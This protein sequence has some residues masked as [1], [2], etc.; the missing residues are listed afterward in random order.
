MELAGED[1]PAAT[2]NDILSPPKRPRSSFSESTL[3]KRKEASAA[4]IG[5]DGALIDSNG[6]SVEQHVPSRRRDT[7]STEGANGA[8]V[9]FSG[10]TG[11]IE[12]K[13]HIYGKEVEN[14]KYRGVKAGCRESKQEKGV[15]KEGRME[16][17][18]NI[19]G[20]GVRGQREG[21]RMSTLFG[22]SSAI[23]I[24]ANY[25]RNREERR[26]GREEG[27]RYKVLGSMELA[28]E[29][30]DKR[31]SSGLKYGI[32]N[33]DG[34]EKGLDGNKGLGSNEEGLREKGLEKAKIDGW[35]V[36]ERWILG[37][38]GEES[39]EKEDVVRRVPGRDE[40]KRII[41]PLL[42][43]ESVFDEQ[44]YVVSG[45]WMKKYCA[46][47]EEC[48][49]Y[50]MKIGPVDQTSLMLE[51]R[52]KDGLLKGKDYEII[53]ST[54]WEY[55]VTWFGVKGEA[56]FQEA[57]EARE[58]Q[59]KTKS[60]PVDSGMGGCV[61]E[62]YVFRLIR[63]KLGSLDGSIGTKGSEGEDDT[64][65]NED[66]IITSKIPSLTTMNPLDESYEHSMMTDA[67][68]EL[69]SDDADEFEWP[70]NQTMMT[71]KTSEMSEEVVPSK[72][73]TSTS[74]SVYLTIDGNATVVALLQSI[75]QTLGLIPTQ[76]VQLWYQGK[77]VMTSWTMLPQETTVKSL[78]LSLNPVLLVETT[79][80][81]V[82]APPTPLST[83]PSSG[84]FSCIFDK[85]QTSSEP[86][87]FPGIQTTSLSKIG[88]VGLQN[89]G[90]SCYM[91][92][93]LQCLTHTSELTTYFLSGVY[94]WE[95]NST[96][97][98]GTG[99][100]LA[101]SYAALLNSLAHTT[102]SSFSPKAFKNCLGRFNL[103]F[104]GHSQQD[105]QE[106]LAFLLDGM[107]EDLNRIQKKPYFEKPALSDMNDALIAETADICW[108]LHRKR[109]D[110]VIVDLFHGLY[111]S[112][113]VCPSCDQ[114][115]ITFDPFMDLTLPLPFKNQWVYP[116]TV[117][118]SDVN[119]KQIQITVELDNLSTIASMKAY[120]ASKLSMNADAL[121][122]S[123]IYAY[124]FYKHHADASIV[125]TYLSPH[126]QV[127]LYEMPCSVSDFV[128]NRHKIVIPVFHQRIEKT[129]QHPVAFGIPFFIL[130]TPEEACS[131][132]LI[133]KKIVEK[134]KQFIRSKEI[135][136][137]QRQQTIQE[138]D[139]AVIT[140]D[141]SQKSMG[142]DHK[143][144]D[145]I[146][147]EIFDLKYFSSRHSVLP[148]GWSVP[149]DRLPKLK[150]R[151]WKSTNVDKS[152][153]DD[154]LLTADSEEEP[155]SH[156]TPISLDDIIEDSDF[157]I[158]KDSTDDELLPTNLVSE[159]TS[160]MS[161]RQEHR[162]R[163]SSEMNIHETKAL[164]NNKVIIRQGE[165]IVC[166]W[167]ADHYT[168][169]FS[170]EIEN[171]LRCSTVWDDVEK[172]EDP[173]LSI[174]REPSTIHL[175][176]CLDLFA[177]K[178]QLG[179]DDLWYCPNCKEH[180]RATKQLEIWKSPDILVIHLKRFSSSRNLR[181]KI[182]VLV[183][184]PLKGLDLSQRVAGYRYDS[185]LTN[186]SQI[187]DL[188]A[189]S[190]HFGGLGG[191]HY[192][193]YVVLEDGHFYHFDDSLVVQVHESQIVTP[194]A[195][196]LFY[197]RRT[198]KVLG[199]STMTKITEY[200]SKISTESYDKINAT[201][202]LTKSLGPAMLN[203][204][205][206]SDPRTISMLNMQSNMTHIDLSIRT[207]DD[208]VNSNSQDSIESG[209]ATFSDGF[210]DNDK[211]EC[212]NSETSM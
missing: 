97:P 89:L 170:N 159:K 34:T 79:D 206:V 52:L 98:L 85:E 142:N 50:G 164:K 199:E 111:K 194:A 43:G 153:D 135:F 63:V 102:T 94:R 22:P 129:Y 28:A 157:S 49:G 40:Q 131:Y 160:H 202:P 62:S 161:L 56:I 201:T 18:Q 4:A 38:C 87:S 208:S 124:K 42:S 8:E 210:D 27:V 115:S 77:Q 190:N 203:E 125:S 15:G 172:Y 178:E 65:N 147:D 100:Q 73:L 81:V 59:S 149:M 99:G 174:R 152:Y 54:V 165:A 36:S 134:Y 53:P 14:E 71:R 78:G 120:V 9:V 204:K 107:H 155:F 10:C 32:G 121:I 144:D 92:A 181:D 91:N 127:Y 167:S 33:K 29:E 116:I 195:Y 138:R 139:T 205:F 212:L 83:E 39:V 112:V 60:L 186:D 191:G 179:E 130:L 93:A 104:A 143:K 146:Y 48:L 173:L 200:I 75:R 163:L 156:G 2:N 150:T 171:G 109:N 175:D 69:S 44:Y 209:K 145:N 45:P 37:V 148:T 177:K 141:F 11:N 72:L 51:G 80:L 19:C 154:I 1:A 169:I 68:D 176:D 123:E 184:F 187:Y 101:R 180:R 67:I 47:L 76:L 46:Y 95:V 182:D 16:K 30:V 74:S 133:V 90:N 17:E 168:S 31:E 207:P 26:E 162:S 24:S 126:D 64:S 128:T 183:D 132:N 61:A 58:E 13:K 23:S 140:V 108:Q 151:F 70:P 12:D 35:G 25:G 110:S 198:D 106:L 118:P 57:L 189:V 88:A 197:R 84:T 113:L 192:T 3:H 21:V 55:L 158:T 196:L 96:N 119:K 5:R 188:Y 166:E 82:P 193:A 136:Q 122:S 20:G 41:E 103:S 105:S 66:E 114:V 117:I 7:S 137:N 86:S 6:E 211:G 185:S